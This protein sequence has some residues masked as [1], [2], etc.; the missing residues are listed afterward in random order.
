MCA[1]LQSQQ[2]PQNKDYIVRLLKIIKTNIYE[3]F[4][5]LNDN[6]SEKLYYELSKKFHPDKIRDFEKE[7]FYLINIH[8]NLHLE[9]DQLKST[10]IFTFQVI[11]NVYNKD[12]S[13]FKDDNHYD[14]GC[15]Y[16]NN[17][18]NFTTWGDDDF[19][20]PQTYSHTKKTDE[21]SNFSHPFY[22]SKNKSPNYSPNK[23]PN[24]GR[25][26]SDFYYGFAW[27]CHD[28]DA[29]INHVLCG[30]NCPRCGE[31]RGDFWELRD[32]EDTTHDNLME[33]ASKIYLSQNFAN[34]LIHYELM[35][36]DEWK[37][38]KKND[39]VRLLNLY[40]QEEDHFLLDMNEYPD[41]YKSNKMVTNE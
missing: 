36:L 20:D 29:T 6:T 23:S 27:V 2:H 26:F 13:D 41:E 11:S 8:E 22:E 34:Y 7:S 40:Y 17:D 10:L 33:N 3:L 38:A 18:T 15:K 21:S 39:N 16:D 35:T 28:C 9:E 5:N 1:Q 25:I 12:Y 14:D 32:D 37:I 19:A 24:F 4:I 30:D 31:K